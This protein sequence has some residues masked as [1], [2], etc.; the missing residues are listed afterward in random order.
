M[1]QRLRIAVTGLGATYPFG[2]V[3]WDYGQYVL[4]LHRL[5]HDVLYIEDTGRWTYDVVEETFVRNGERNAA[6]FSRQIAALEPELADRW[7]FRDAEGRTYGRAWPDV[8]AFCRAADLFLH[9]SASCWMRDEYFAA[10]R[11]AFIDSDPMYTQASVPDYVS[12]GAHSIAP[13]ARERR[14]NLTTI[15]H[16]QQRVTDAFGAEPVASR[17]D[18]H[19]ATLVSADQ[20][21]MYLASR[22]THASAAE[23]GHLL[24]VHDEP[25]VDHAIRTLPGLLQEDPAFG[26]EVEQVAGRVRV[27]VLRQHDVFFTFAENIG[28]SDCRVPGEVFDWIPT[29]QPIVLDCFRSAWVPVSDRRRALTTVASW[30]STEGGPTVGGVEYGGKHIEFERFIE[31][32][33]R[34]AVPLELALSGRPPRERLAR[35][36]WQLIDP[37]QVSSDPWVYRE[38]LAH[39]FGEWSVAKNAYAA[40]RSGW[41]SCRTA[42]YLALGVPAV[43]QDT[44]F[45]AAIPTGEGILAFSTLDEAV[46]SIERLLGDP[47]RHARAATAL[48]DEYF[49]SD[50]VLTRLIERA[51]SGSDCV[52]VRPAK[53]HG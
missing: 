12:A 31:L 33:T 39:S 5:G 7:F 29:R 13:G 19:P 44:G 32:P 47:H 2:G 42:C 50:K 22:L 36:G 27:D 17:S 23:I 18:N 10:T 25:S 37:C 20:I 35:H 34:V 49:D 3:F 6:F 48:A 45:G 51:M 53:A 52:S 38:Y 11:V 46:D 43:V 15:H 40:S 24:G 14:P 9:I 16:I 4:G 30:E 8:V 41:F 21:A 28:A 1:P 26:R